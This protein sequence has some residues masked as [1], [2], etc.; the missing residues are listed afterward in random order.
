[1]NYKIKIDNIGKLKEANISV[2]SLTIL[3]GP[4]NTGKSFFSK[5]LYSVF[6]A[7]NTNPVLVLIQYCLKR[8]E[9]SSERIERD[10]FITSIKMREEQ[11]N[12]E[13][14]SSKQKRKPIRLAIRSLKECYLLISKKEDQIFTSIRNDFKIN[15]TDII[16]AINKVVESY[17]QLLNTISNEEEI[18][19]IKKSIST[20]KKLIGS[21]S[22]TIIAQGFNRA[23]ETNL[24]G[25]FQIPNLQDLK[26]DKKKTSIY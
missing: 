1:M 15:D 20:L 3:A 25:N 11:K 21:N 5:T 26:R 2:C 6:N 10:I 8:L 9:E 16:E 14:E 22:E 19:E 13:K 24:I 17:T 7:M 23:L 4:N 12:N 18:N